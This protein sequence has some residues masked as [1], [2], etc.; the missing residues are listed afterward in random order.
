MFARVMAMVENR[1][2]T[3]TVP[4]RAVTEIQGT[5]QVWVVDSEGKANVRNVKLADRKGTNWVVAE[6]LQG[7]EKIVVEGVQ[8]L[9][10][11]IPVRAV[12]FVPP[13]S[14]QGS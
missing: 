6:G 13:A 2:N 10:P 14:P 7:G 8:K 12:P 11:G 5:Y 4:Q 3:I 1:K 9:R